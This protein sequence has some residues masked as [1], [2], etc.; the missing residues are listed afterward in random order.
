MEKLEIDKKC[1]DLLLSRAYKQILCSIM[2]CIKFRQNKDKSAEK[3]FQLDKISLL[4]SY[5]L[6]LSLPLRN[7]IKLSKRKWIVIVKFCYETGF[8]R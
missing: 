5:S 2:R 8:S 4:I 1:G 3:Y 6:S 7:R